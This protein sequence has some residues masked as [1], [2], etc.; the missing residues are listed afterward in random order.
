MSIR[1]ALQI[2][3]FIPGIQDLESVL[4]TGDDANELSITNLNNLDVNSINGGSIGT[5]TLEQVLIN[6]N[7]AGLQDISGVNNI[8]VNSVNGVSLFNTLTFIDLSNTAIIIN[9]TTPIDIPSSSITLLQGKYIVTSKVNLSSAAVTSYTISLFLGANLLNSSTTSGTGITGASLTIPAYPVNVTTASDTLILKLSSVAPLATTV[10]VV[11]PE[12][13][14]IVATQLYKGI[15]PTPAIQ[16]R[17]TQQAVSTEWASLA[18]SS[19]GVTLIG[20]GGG[21]VGYVFTSVNSGTTWTQRTTAATNKIYRAIACS[22]TGAKMIA[23]AY[24]GYIYTSTDSGVTWTERTGSGSRNWHGAG[25]SSDGVKLVACVYG[26]Y[27]YTS[28]DS[29]VTWTERTG[30]GNRNFK[31]VVSSSDG[32]KLATC[33]FG[34]YIYTSTDSGV[35]WT[36]R[37]GSGS[38]EWNSIASSS[39][40]VKLVA[41]VKNGYIYTSVDSGVTWTERTS[42]GSRRW[43]NMACS[44]DGVNLFVP[45]SVSP[46]R[47]V[48]SST[49]SGAN[50]TALTGTGEYSWNTVASDST[51]F[52]IIAGVNTGYI[53]RGVFS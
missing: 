17:W 9:N 43:N 30:A 26:G 7:N 38:R 5:E 32:L 36:E 29:G 41:V 4:I 47:Y 1:S 11:A 15:P 48:W 2:D 35:T 23:G 10:T 16:W 34:G 45:N 6:G 50:W 52:K 19:D 42:A 27:I 13:S 12:A 49:D 44:S 28:T 53:Y 22:S 8:N 21:V 39:D 46:D 3:R 40:G 51:G 18:S 24:G 33:V 25:S 20:G 14:Y 37:T 31:M